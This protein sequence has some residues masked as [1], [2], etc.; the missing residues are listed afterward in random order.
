MLPS[1]AVF[2]PTDTPSLTS[3]KHQFPHRPYQPLDP[4]CSSEHAAVAFF[5]SM[6]LRR[7]VR[8]FSDRPVSRETIEKLILTA[9]SAPS[10]ANK[11][12]WR[13]VAVSDPVMKRKIRL[14][15]EQEEREFYGGRASQEWLQD[16]EPFETN[17]EK[18]FL[19][20]APWLI[21]VF[22]Q[23]KTEDGKKVYYPLESVGLASGFLLA[24]IHQAGLASLTH[25]PS[26]M[27]FLAQIL[28]RPENERPFLLI[29][30]GYPAADCEVPDIAKK[31]LDEIAVFL[32]SCPEG[33]A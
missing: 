3:S 25:T 1:K 11:Q 12:G 5:N 2:P 10:G 16:L 13:F 24:A 7:S 33:E 4:G 14:A 27:K 20:T 15:A 22:Y 9:G 26:P 28:G 8:A 21:V 23:Q 29:P 19:E 30:L 6:K 32:E 17:P 18:P 31:S